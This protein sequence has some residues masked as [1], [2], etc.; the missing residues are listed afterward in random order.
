MS[1]FYLGTYVGMYYAGEKKCDWMVGGSV[2]LLL[3]HA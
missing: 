3:R 2:S 1:D